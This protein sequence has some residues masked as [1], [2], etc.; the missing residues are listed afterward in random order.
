MNRE[1]K[2][3]QSDYCFLE[4][5]LRLWYVQYP[6][7]IS[8]E[9]LMYT[10]QDYQNKYGLE[11]LRQAM[12]ELTNVLLSEQLERVKDDANLRRHR[13]AGEA[14]ARRQRRMRSREKAGVNHQNGN[15]TGKTGNP[16]YYRG[17]KRCA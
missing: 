1:S 16:G 13:D 9:A 4:Q 8:I 12:S 6:P 2:E 3:W 11:A 10:K 15:H 7:E 14:D 17:N 5:Q